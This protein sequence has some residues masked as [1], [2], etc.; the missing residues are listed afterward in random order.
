MLSDQLN[1]HASHS[2][3][4]SSQLTSLADSSIFLGL[5]CYRCCRFNATLPSSIVIA[6]ASRCER[7]CQA[8][9]TSACFVSCIHALNS[10]FVRGPFKSDPL[11]RKLTDTPASALR[12][13]LSNPTA[14][15]FINACT[16]NP[17]MHAYSKAKQASR[18]LYAPGLRYET[19]RFLS[20]TVAKHTE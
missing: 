3:S 18:I 11:T 14:P 4:P 17:C 9:L 1:A 20:P 15:K 5:N 7:K 2:R 16:L 6:T 10:R 8:S 13:R 19:M 12:Q